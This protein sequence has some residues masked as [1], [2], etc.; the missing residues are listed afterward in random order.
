MEAKF[1]S[2]NGTMERKKKRFG[3][4]ESFLSRYT[5]KPGT[6]PLLNT[7]WIK[8]QSPGKIM[9]QLC[10]NVIFAHWLAGPGEEPFVV[11]L[12]TRDSANEES[13]FRAHLLGDSVRFARRTWEDIFTL[14]TFEPQGALSKYVRNKTIKLRPAFRIPA[15]VGS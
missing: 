10:R 5:C 7:A 9:E 1:G 6:G 14:P 11:N 15:Q 13:H 3:S 8:E 12:V 4:V 2:K